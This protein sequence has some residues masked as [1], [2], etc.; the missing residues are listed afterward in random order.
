LMVDQAMD[1]WV[2]TGAGFTPVSP[3]NVKY[4]MDPD[5]AA[6]SAGFPAGGGLT[7]Y[8]DAGMPTNWYTE[9]SYPIGTAPYPVGGTNSVAPKGPLTTMLPTNATA[10]TGLISWTKIT[11]VQVAAVLAVIVVIYMLW[12]KRQSKGGSA[13]PGPATQ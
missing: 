2:V 11:W 1:L 10:P 3:D 8:G 9:A 4:Y 6:L 5:L 7:F 12:K 13:T